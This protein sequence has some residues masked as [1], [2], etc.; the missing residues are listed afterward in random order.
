MALLSHGKLVS[1]YSNSQRKMK[2]NNTCFVVD[3]LKFER[4]KNKMLQL[5]RSA[6]MFNMPMQPRS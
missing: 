4:N 2:E 1:V 5:Y 3:M 6:V